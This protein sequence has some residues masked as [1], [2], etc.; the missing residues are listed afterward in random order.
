M[1]E[2]ISFAEIVINYPETVKNSIREKGVG[3][4]LVQFKTD[5]NFTP[6]HEFALLGEVGLVF[7][8]LEPENLK[9]K[10]A[11]G[12]TPLYWA[13]KY[14]NPLVAEILFLA[15]LENFVGIKNAEEEFKKPAGVIS[16]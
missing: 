3:Y 7:Q 10:D 5:L 8:N 16:V 13:I 15:H 12:H 1:K 4:S 2:N 11:T 9:A 6:L 14:G